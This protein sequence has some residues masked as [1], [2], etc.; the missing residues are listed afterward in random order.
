MINRI[1]KMSFREEEK[2]AFLDLFEE[3]KD[4]IRNFNGCCGLTLLEDLQNSNTLFTYSYW[5]SE[6]HLNA[7]RNSKLFEKT[8]ENTK[9]KF[10]NKAEAWSLLVK[11]NP[12]NNKT[13][14][15]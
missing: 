13:Q 3:V 6:E 1:V 7:Y 11:S 5:E 4:K 8:W 9:N 14:S 10:A 12:S 2:E 15:F